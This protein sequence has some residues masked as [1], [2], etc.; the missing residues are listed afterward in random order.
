MLMSSEGQCTGKRG[1]SKCNH[2][3]KTI[4]GPRGSTADW[5]Q[6]P[7]PPHIPLGCWAL[8]PRSFLTFRISFSS[9]LSLSCFC[10][11]GR[12]LGVYGLNYVPPNSHAE[13]LTPNISE[14]DLAWRWSL[15]RGNQVKRRSFG[16]AVIQSDWCL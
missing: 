4:Q 13:V 8:H 15:C 1:V 3:M 9:S 11:K 16:C 7:S 6:N 12:R 5:K 10:P 2:K 14:G